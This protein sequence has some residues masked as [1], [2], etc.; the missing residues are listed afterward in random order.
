MCTRHLG[1]ALVSISAFCSS[2][3]SVY[4]PEPFWPDGCWCK[5]EILNA[6][7]PFWVYLAPIA[8]LGIAFFEL[9]YGYYQFLRIVITTACVWI[10][11]R[12][13]STGH[14]V[15]VI[16]F[17]FMA[18]LFNPIAKIHMERETHEVMNVA[19][20]L[21]FAAAWFFQFRH[22]PKSPDD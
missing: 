8:L 20:A 11:V 22:A 19:T 15:G 4:D 21:L 18:V 6:R 17:G 9:P 12:F 3:S 10:A 1:L 16:I 7:L 14:V 13:Y 2:R 5:R